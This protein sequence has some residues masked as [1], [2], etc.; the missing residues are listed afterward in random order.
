M[1]V[2]FD[3]DCAIC[4]SFLIFVDKHSSKHSKQI[5]ATASAKLFCKISSSLEYEYVSNLQAKTIIVDDNGLILQRSRAIAVILSSTGARRLIILSF[6]I[7]VIPCRIA[8]LGYSMIAGI[9]KRLL[10][11]KRTCRLYAFKYIDIVE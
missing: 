8:D 7:V 1:I 6:L 5:R 2:L 11:E 3:G 4:N 10:S 9:R